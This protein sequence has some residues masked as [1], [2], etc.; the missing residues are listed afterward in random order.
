MPRPK[1]EREPSCPISLSTDGRYHGYLLVGKKLNGDDDVRHRSGKDPKKVAAAIIKLEDEIAAKNGE[2]PA[3]GRRMK[4]KDYL[5]QW[6]AEG[7][8]PQKQS[9][10]TMRARWKHATAR[11]YLLTIENY[12]IPHAGEWRLDQFANSP[13][14]SKNLLA[15]VAEKV[16]AHAAGKARRVLRSALADAVADGL[17]DRN[18]MRDINKKHVPA[19][20][21]KEP[22]WLTVE[23]GRRLLEAVAARPRLQSRWLVA[24]MLGLRQGECLALKWTRPALRGAV[25]DIN[26][27]TGELTI[28]KK[29]ERHSW[30]HGCGDAVACVKGRTKTNAQGVEVPHNICK[31]T[32]CGPKWIHGCRAEPCSYESP[33]YCPARKQDGC[34]R[35][36]T[37][38]GKAKDCPPPC[39][40]DCD[41]HA[42]TCPKAVGG[43]LYEEDPKTKAGNRTVQ[44]PRQ[45][46]DAF[47]ARKAE[48]DAERE[49]AANLWQDTGYIHTTEWGAEVDPRRDW[50]DWHKLLREAKVD[51]IKLHAARHYACTILILIGIPKHTIMHILGWSTDMTTR[52]GHILNEM[53]REVAGKLEEFHWGAP[54]VAVASA[55]SPAATQQDLLAAMEEM[56][57]M[58]ASLQTKPVP[59][60]PDSSTSGSTS[61]VIQGPWKAA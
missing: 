2:A 29:L 6:Y 47:I 58:I 34:W 48:Q 16:S 53:V 50:E 19:I 59:S 24:L 28:R 37:K 44:L 52:Y 30:L 38:D 56:R 43:G 25:G 4:L 3:V 42:S 61:N 18:A 41:G 5:R 60:A 33:R 22:E 51:P 46:W 14:H 45:L 15:A 57:A 39:K 7:T 11:D 31:V 23:E 9:D 1:K 36:R 49:K 13:E 32:E 10:D 40:Q 35:H 54:A 8:R 20:V 21:E 27:A 55:A 17:A 12:I 26:L